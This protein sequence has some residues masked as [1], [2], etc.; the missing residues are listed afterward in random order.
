MYVK[1]P[2]TYAVM[3]WLGAQLLRRWPAA[4]KTLSVFNTALIALGEWWQGLRKAT[5]EAARLAGTTG[6]RAAYIRA[7]EE[8]ALR[9]FDAVVFGHTHHAGQIELPNGS[10]YFNTGQWD[11]DPHYVAIDGGRV[12][13]HPIPP[14]AG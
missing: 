7:A 2:R 11:G 8:I 9:G 10:W 6:E 1:Y 13:L 14:R 12:S 4:Y 5:D 3:T